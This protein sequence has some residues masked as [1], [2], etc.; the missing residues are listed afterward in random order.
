MQRLASFPAAPH[1]DPLLNGKLVPFSFCHKHHLLKLNS[2]Q[3]VLHRP[4]ETAGVKETE[5]SE[6][7]FGPQRVRF[8]PRPTCRIF[9]G[10]HG[11]KV[12][13]M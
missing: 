7:S 3:M 11:S 10:L 1:V 8:D 13:V 12:M 2:Y 9:R 5:I 6:Q 4:V